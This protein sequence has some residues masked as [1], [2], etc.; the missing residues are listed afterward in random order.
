MLDDF[1]LYDWYTLLGSTVALILAILQ[2]RSYLQDQV[3]L[4]IDLD[5]C[6]VRVVPP[7]KEKSGYP[8]EKGFTSIFIDADIQNTGK[9]PVTIS[10]IK[11][12]SENSK[13]TNIDMFY[14]MKSFDGLAD[15]LTEPLRINSNDRLDIE[16]YC[17]NCEYVKDLESLSC[18]LLFYTGQ[19]NIKKKFKIEHQKLIQ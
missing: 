4:A 16:I 17:P 19:K 18:F 9:Q 1:S 7:N 2:I 14:S 13:F 10:K 3:K 5:L 11:L 8:E 12:F 6:H 15:T